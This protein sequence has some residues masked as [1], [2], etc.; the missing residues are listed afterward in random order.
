MCIR[1][2]IDSIIGGILKDVPQAVELKLPTLKK[3]GDSTPQ[4]IKLPKLTKV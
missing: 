3:A 2:R 4:K 1:D